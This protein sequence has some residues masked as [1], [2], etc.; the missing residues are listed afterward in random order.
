MDS[1]TEAEIHYIMKKTV[2][3]MRTAGH[4]FTGVLYGGFMVTADGPMVLEFNCRFGDPETQVCNIR[5]VSLRS[6]Y[7][8]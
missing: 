3:A 7:L 6:P 1:G 5:N 4:P 8:M 2:L